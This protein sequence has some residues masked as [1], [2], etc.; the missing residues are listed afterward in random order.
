MFFF[1][2]LLNTYGACWLLGKWT[3][4]AGSRKKISDFVQKY[5]IG[6]DEIELPLDQYDNLNAFFSRKLKPEARSFVA[7]PDVFCSPVDGKVLVYSQLD[8][9]TQLPVKEAYVDIVNLMASEEASAPY[10]GGS[11][12]VIRLAPGDYHR[13]HFPVKG[14]ATKA[15]EIFGRYYLVNPIALDVKPDL[16]AHN[17]RMVTYLETEGFGRVMIMEVAGWA[18]GRMV[19]T[20]TPGVVTR[21]QEKGYFQF[22]GS[23]VV[24]LFE[25][26]RIVFDEDLARDTQDRIEVQVLLGTQ[27]GMRLGS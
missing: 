20:Y 9:Q 16:F 2:L 14:T 22:G 19:Q 21:G 15:T 6:L 1:N 26:G 12:L 5:N 10:A 23:T 8:G 17:K 27:L 4:L 13:Y 11:A 24:I 7:D 3:D 18:V 25:P